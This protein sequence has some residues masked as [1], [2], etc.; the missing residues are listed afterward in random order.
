MR[1]R[2]SVVATVLLVSVIAAFVPTMLLV[3][4]ARAQE[5]LRGDVNGDGKVDISDLSLAALAYGA[6]GPDG[7]NHQSPGLPASARWEPWGPHADFDHNNLVDIYDLLI[8]A[9][10]F[11]TTA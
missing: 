7:P 2:I 3:N 8:I 1:K 10:N 4:T 9:K 6:Y 11:G 5:P